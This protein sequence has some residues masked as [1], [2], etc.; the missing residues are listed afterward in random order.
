VGKF[1][2]FEIHFF[3]IRM[4]GRP[5]KRRK[6]GKQK[7]CDDDD[8]EN[9]QLLK[10]LIENLRTH[11][12]DVHSTASSANSNDCKKVLRKMKSI[13]PVIVDAFIVKSSTKSNYISLVLDI[14][15]MLI[16]KEVCD[17]GAVV[18]DH[19]EEATFLQY[20]FHFLRLGI[21]IDDRI[22][23]KLIDVI[24]LMCD[25][26][27]VEFLTDRYVCILRDL[28]TFLSDSYVVLEALRTTSS[29][30]SSSP[31]II[32]TILGQSNIL[33]KS[34]TNFDIKTLNSCEATSRCIY[35]LESVLSRTIGNGGA[36][37]CEMHSIKVP[38]WNSIRRAIKT[39]RITSVT[40]LELLQTLINCCH[41]P[42][43]LLRVQLFTR[44]LDTKIIKEDRKFKL[45][46]S[47]L[48]DE[49]FDASSNL[50]DA[51]L[52]KLFFTSSNL[53]CS[54]RSI[55][56]GSNVLVRTIQR[57][58][59][60]NSHLNMLTP[61]MVRRE[62]HEYA[63]QCVRAVSVSEQT[64]SQ[65]QQQLFPVHDETQLRNTMKLLYIR[66]TRKLAPSHDVQL[67]ENA[68]TTL[69]QEANRMN[70]A[71]RA[72]ENL[73]TFSTHVAKV[74]LQH[75]IRKNN[76]DIQALD[77]ILVLLHKSY[78]L[79]RQDDFITRMAKKISDRILKNNK[80]QLDRSVLLTL[81]VW[82]SSLDDLKGYGHELIR[83]SM[84]SSLSSCNDNIHTITCILVQ[85]IASSPSK[86]QAAKRSRV[87]LN[88]IREMPLRDAVFAIGRF[89]CASSGCCSSI[90]SSKVMFDDENETVLQ[91]R[92]CD[93]LQDVKND[94]C[95]SG[96]VLALFPFLERALSS[97]ENEQIRVEATKSLGRL[98]VHVPELE[99]S[100]QSRSAL[101]FL[102]LM[103]SDNSSAVRE[104]ATSQIRLILIPQVRARLFPVLFPGSSAA[105]VSSTSQNSTQ[106]ASDFNNLT[107]FIR[108]IGNHLNFN[109]NDDILI[110]GIANAG[111][112]MR[113]ERTFRCWTILK[114]VEAWCTYDVG[115]VFE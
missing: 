76:L 23:E 27:Y 101:T 49:T 14:F 84:S 22:R 81:L 98:L 79:T 63:L 35:V 73:D 87:A 102:N 71:L 105:S 74:F 32:L 38:L 29:S 80:Q 57:F 45:L 18:F 97:S 107:E 82:P 4:E 41:V 77:T 59:L 115:V 112:I 96:V 70:F 36:Q 106:S 5:G 90:S 1:Q 103:F 64:T 78:D 17:F 58:G 72:S 69:V 21:E 10:E 25:L 55:Q 15:R 20:I 39:T 43:S 65:E 7:Q 92:S 3:K 93:M 16:S 19:G 67:D 24:V 109:N 110:R 88:H 94:V 113:S 12:S 62:F 100:T 52:P 44:I 60:W 2:T 33:Y 28:V 68:T 61:L 26:L 53:S 30:S 11:H 86:T 54:S 56:F 85:W 46:E 104:A 89:V 66:F 34:E 114:L 83:S 6:K 99:I 42:E 47:L 91:C 37:F 51:A 108:Q 31:S 8:D 13:L 50:I 9:T 75:A 48:D 111:S 95:S 40:L